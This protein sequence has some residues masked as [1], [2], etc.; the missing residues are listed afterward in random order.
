[1]SRP[2]LPAGTVTFLFTDIEGSTRLLER[3]G[4]TYDGALEQHHHLLATAI[5]EAGG[6]LVATEGDAVFAAFERVGQALDAALRA[7][8]A[9]HLHPWP[10]EG[11]IRVRMGIHTGEAR[12]GP[13]G[14]IGLPVN[15][16][17]RTSAAA[18]GGQVL[19]SATSRL[20]AE[21]QL[22]DG[23]W[24]QDMGDHRLKDI[25]DRQRLFQ[26]CHADLPDDFPVLRTLDATPNNLRAHL[27]SFIGRIDE[28]ASL[29]RT[30]DD[31]RLVTLTGAGG[32][33]KTRIAQEF[34]GERLNEFP[35][36]VFLVELGA[37]TEGPLAVDAVAATLGVREDAA[38]SSTNDVLAAIESFVRDKRLLLLLDNCEHLVEVCAE[39]ADRLLAAAPDLRIVATSREPLGVTGESV[40]RIGSLSIEDDAVRLFVD[41]ASTADPAFSPTESDEAVI[42]EICRRLDGIP[43]AVELAAAKV[44][45]LA[46]DQIAARLDDMF[47]LLTGGSR[48]ALPRQQ[49]LQAAVDWSY[50]LLDDEERAVLRRMAAFAGDC[51]LE[52]AEA[53]CAGEPVADVAV[54]DVLGQLVDKSLVNVE[55]SPVARYRLLEP[56]R[57]YAVPKLVEAGEAQLARHAHLA[58]YARLV[59][60]ASAG[61]ATAAEAH[62]AAA[63]DIEHDNIQA[64]LQWSVA[65]GDPGLGVLMA[66]RLTPYWALRGQLTEGIDWLTRTLEA[67]PPDC[68]GRARAHYGRGQLRR[69]LGEPATADMEDCIAVAADIDDRLSS[70]GTAQAHVHLAIASATS[71]PDGAAEHLAIAEKIAAA[72]GDPAVQSVVA[73]GRAAI[74]EAAGERDEAAAAHLESIRLARAAGAPSYIASALV[75]SAEYLLDDAPHDAI[76]LLEEALECSGVGQEGRV[77]LDLAIAFAMVGDLEGAVVAAQ[78]AADLARRLGAR[79]LEAQIRALLDRLGSEDATT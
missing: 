38:A 51:A 49:T 76:P 9:L 78:T 33:G 3:L 59:V 14:Y 18:H 56:I 7:Q 16:A 4:T 22:P 61:L 46:P 54:L 62:W 71:D 67:A 20:L 66:G 48:T 43:L 73:R 35:D 41:R 13:T 6:H 30:V 31:S 68:P 79:Q 63:L 65:E 75:R 52:A 37:I 15:Q 17:A 69:Q 50:D 55:R 21:D 23:V 42:V 47:R 77:R 29:K 45:I 60:G 19:V 27:T 70:E 8:R 58:H 72:W 25:S 74:H 39:V 12:L 64:A 5:E 53:V 36:G 32:C 28:M 10:P 34:A 57:Q 11:R 44:R 24:L 1:M 26:L 2:D 40:F